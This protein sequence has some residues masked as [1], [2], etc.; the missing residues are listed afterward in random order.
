MERAQKGRGLRRIGRRT[1][2]ADGVC[3]HAGDGAAWLI[4]AA[5]EDGARGL[6]EREVWMW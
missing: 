1:D 6:D 5:G 4:L 3:W 2:F